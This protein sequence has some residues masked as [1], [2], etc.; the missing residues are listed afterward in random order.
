MI[1]LASKAAHGLAACCVPSACI[2][3]QIPNL[4]LVVMVREPVEWL[5]PT[6]QTLPV[7]T[8]KLVRIH[9]GTEPSR[10]LDEGPDCAVHEV[11]LQ[12]AKVLS[13]TRL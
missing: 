4:R 12:P 1:R 3:C 10:L 11:A 5:E 2:P 8:I 6:P 9:M 13:V 7:S